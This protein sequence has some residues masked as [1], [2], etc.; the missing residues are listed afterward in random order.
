MI[1]RSSREHSSALNSGYRLRN[2]ASATFRKDS[3]ISNAS[4]SRWELVIR[5]KIS[6]RTAAAS[7]VVSKGIVAATLASVP[8]G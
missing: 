2:P 5:R 1:R 3:L 8:I 7:G 4:R 6:S